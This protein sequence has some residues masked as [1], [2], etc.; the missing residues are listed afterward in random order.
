[1]E[2]QAH[3]VRVLKV[4]FFMVPESHIAAILCKQMLAGP[5]GG[6]QTHTPLGGACPSMTLREAS[7]AVCLRSPL[8]R[9]FT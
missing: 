8:T 5:H 6:E 9:R 3:K 2:G 7:L 4:D 1:M